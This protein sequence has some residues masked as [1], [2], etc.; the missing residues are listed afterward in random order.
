MLSSLVVLFIAS[1]YLLGLQ[2]PLWLHALLTGGVGLTP[3][4]ATSK[5]HYIHH[6]DCRYNRALY[7]TW[8]DRLFETHT[9]R[10]PLIKEDLKRTSSFTNL[11]NNL[12]RFW[13]ANV[14]VRL[15]SMR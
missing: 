5:T 9:D 15:A 6:V 14:N 10:H 12:S 2:T 4:A 13:A 7:F 8:W 11:M 3:W 1:M